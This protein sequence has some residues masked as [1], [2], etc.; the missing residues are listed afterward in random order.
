MDGVALTTT[1]NPRGEDSRLIRLLP[2]LE[3]IYCSITIVMPPGTDQTLLTRL[4]SYGKRKQGKLYTLQAEDWSWGR[5]LA[6]KASLTQDYA[7]VHYADMDRLL[8]WFELEPDELRQV[9]TLIPGSDYTVIGRNAHAYRTHPKALV[10]TEAISNRVIS[11]LTGID[12]DVS[13]GSKGFNRRCVEY[14]VENTR[15]GKAIGTDGEWTVILY[16]KGFRISSILVSGLDW[17]SADRFQEHAAT[18][19]TQAQAA[20]NYDMDPENWARRAE[21]AMEIVEMSLYAARR[22]LP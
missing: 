20:Q 4:S 11:F 14:L 15:P 3:Q 19:E 17:E 1:W 8:R 16:R 7:Y 21:I 13:A 12:L 10:Q 9:V 22:E 5:Y 6:L 2:D 18:I